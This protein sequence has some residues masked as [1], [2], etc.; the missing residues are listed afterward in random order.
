MKGTFSKSE[1]EKSSLAEKALF[2]LISCAMVFFCCVHDMKRGLV[3][4]FINDGITVV[5]GSGAKIEQCT[6]RLSTLVIT[7]L[8]K[9]W[10]TE[11]V[12][13]MH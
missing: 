4:S 10:C 12:P 2:F 9:K 7:V 5:K 6:L 8:E 1:Y 13:H 11:I 3:S